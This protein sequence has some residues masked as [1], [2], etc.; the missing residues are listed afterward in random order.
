VLTEK[1]R[2]AYANERWMDL[3]SS[4]ILPVDRREPRLPQYEWQAIKAKIHEAS[5]YKCCY[6]GVDA[7]PRPICDHVVPISRG[8]T[9]D[10]AN[11]VTACD[12]CNASKGNLTL[13][14]WQRKRAGA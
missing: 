7:R 6:C 1:K 8:G 13:S 12:P 4:P 2:Y 11:L 3:A 9:N 10:P 5:G 14:E